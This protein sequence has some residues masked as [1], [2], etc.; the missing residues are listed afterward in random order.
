MPRFLFEDQHL[1]TTEDLIRRVRNFR[2]WELNIIR[3]AY[4][5][6]QNSEAKLLTNGNKSQLQE[7]ICLAIEKEEK[8]T[9]RLEFISKAIER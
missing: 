6:K 7:M 2:V 8:E 3:Q 5:S 9:G 1:V 4:D